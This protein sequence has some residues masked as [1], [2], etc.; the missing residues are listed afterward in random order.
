[1]LVPIAGDAA[2]RMCDECATK[3]IDAL[4]ATHGKRDDAS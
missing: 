4:E 1:L 2:S 3:V